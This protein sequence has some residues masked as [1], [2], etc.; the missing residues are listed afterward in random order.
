MTKPKKQMT[1][2]QA[3]QI[4][5]FKDLSA[6]EKS[7]VKECQVAIRETTAHLRDLNRD[8]KEAKRQLSET[9]RR[10]KN[11]MKKYKGWAK[12]SVS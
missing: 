10:L 2:E 12:P 3:T 7:A 11:L 6:F 1:V 4:S 5:D 8:L 9:D